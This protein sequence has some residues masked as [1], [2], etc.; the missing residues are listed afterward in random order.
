MNFSAAYLAAL[1]CQLHAARQA[2]WRV[3][4]LA[5]STLVLVSPVFLGGCSKFLPGSAKGGST[6]ANAPPSNAHLM[7]TPNPVP[8]RGQLGKTTLSWGTLDGSDCQIFVSRDG[9][10][11]Q[12]LKQ[13]AEGSDDIPWI[14]P[15]AVYEFR[16]Y[17]GLEHREVL[18]SVTVKGVQAEH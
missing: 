15:G 6:G 7:A 5:A 17:A 1:M 2:L 10:A 4:I 8:V 11:E 18:A 14:E 12:L 13:G 16:L 3:A 9:G